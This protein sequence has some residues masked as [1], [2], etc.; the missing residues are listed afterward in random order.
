MAALSTSF[1]KKLAARDHVIDASNVHLDDAPRANVEVPD[2]AVAH[3]AFGQAHE[4]AV[5][6]NQSMRILAPQPVEVRRASHR[7]GIVF[8]IGVFSPAIHDGEDNG[9]WSVRASHKQVVF[10]YAKSRI[11]FPLVTP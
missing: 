6:P 2:L 1:E 11:A 9:T 3:L 4:G 5:R 10:H 7:D 8:R